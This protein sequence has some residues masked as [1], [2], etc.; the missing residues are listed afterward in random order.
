MPASPE[1][2]KSRLDFALNVAREAS[3]LILTYYQNPNL[4]I[5]SKRDTS[6]VTEGNC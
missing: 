2:L 5:E 1:S 3:A 4:E 6:P